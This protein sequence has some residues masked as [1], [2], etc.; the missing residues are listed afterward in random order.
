MQNQGPI[1]TERS[2]VKLCDDQPYYLFHGNPSGWE[3]RF[4]YVQA[5]HT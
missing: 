4:A 3:M 2:H 5:L 1:L